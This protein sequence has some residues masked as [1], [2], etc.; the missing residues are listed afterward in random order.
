MQAHRV[1]ELALF[2]WLGLAA[3]VGLALWVSAS[4]APPSAPVHA[5]DVVPPHTSTPACV[6]AVVNGG[7]ETIS[8]GEATPWVRSG[9]VAYITDTHYSGS[10]AAAL[11]GANDAT[12]RL[13]QD[14]VLPGDDL[15]TKVNELSL[16]YYYGVLTDETEHP[17]DSLYVRLY[18]TADQLLTTLETLTDN[19]PNAWQQSQFDLLAYKGQTVRLAF[20]VETDAQNA[21]TF[22]LDDVGLNVCQIVQP[23]PTNTPEPTST[24]TSTPTYTP[25]FTHTPLA[26]ATPSMTPTPVT[27]SFRAGDNGYTSTYDSFLDSWYP[28][29][30]Y[31]AI[32]LLNIRSD[33]AR[34]PVIYFDLSAIPAGVTILDARLWLMT[35]FYRS[36]PQIITV[37]AYG[38]K[39]AWVENEVSWEVAQGDDQWAVPG[40]NSI[41]ADRDAVATAS[42]EIYDTATTYDLDLTPLVQAWVN[43]SRPNYGLLLV[44]SGNTCEMRF[45]SSASSV[46]SQRPR[47]VVTYRGGGVSPTSTY[48]PLPGPSATPTAA[49]S[50]TPTATV[51]GPEIVLQNGLNGYTGV[52]DTYLSGSRPETLAPTLV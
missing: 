10:Y 27:V 31:G 4:I 43:G 49:A 35:D 34:R 47:L 37:S 33:D 7:Y 24:S 19:D 50:P 38:L 17:A 14:L 44:G 25:T 42:R 22:F 32:S 3:L 28:R 23:T 20:E 12:G 48:T 51:P 9:S 11:G 21:T 36:H 46:L 39:R 8:E 29:A 6:S 52:V 1:P 13:Y 16:S 2:R 26:S 18:D 45:F 30:N 41:T 40:A 5:E 15:P